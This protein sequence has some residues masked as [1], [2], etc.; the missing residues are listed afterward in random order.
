MKNTW[1]ALMPVAVLLAACGVDANGNTAESTYALTAQ[2][3]DAGSGHPG[4][5]RPPQGPP[6]EALAV[7][8]N[9][10]AQDACTFIG[11]QGETVS[12]TCRNGPDGNGPLACAPAQPP[13]QGQGDG[14]Q[15]PH[16][17]Q[18]AI[19]ACAGISE[20]GACGFTTQDGNNVTGN[21]KTGPNGEPAAC[22]PAQQ[23]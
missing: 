3:A 9:L 6:P 1:W 4:C 10:A 7:C 13:A 20:N 2:S 12:G 5:D 16:P 18:E 23:P 17:P 21:C 19:T 11:R 22:A 8:Q 14:G 15:P